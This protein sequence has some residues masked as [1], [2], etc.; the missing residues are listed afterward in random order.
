MVD[1][2]KIVKIKLNEDITIIQFS[3]RCF[4]IVINVLK[5][6]VSKSQKEI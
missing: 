6:K 3:L 1:V 5:Q 4:L 2:S